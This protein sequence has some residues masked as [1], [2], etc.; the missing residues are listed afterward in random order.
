MV[1]TP[2]GIVILLRL[3]Q[4]ENAEP[5]ME[6]TPSGIVILV[7]LLQPANAYSPMVVTPF[8]ITTALMLSR[9]WY[10]GAPL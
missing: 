7:R 10:Q 8:S 3:L 2:S 5:P 9:L 6:V 1:V 4:P